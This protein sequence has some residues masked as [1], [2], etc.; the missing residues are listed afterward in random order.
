MKNHLIILIIF[1]VPGFLS[2][3]NLVHNW[4]FEDTIS[5]PDNATQINLSKYWFQPNVNG[6][7]SE[8]Y[9]S[10][11]DNNTVGVPKNGLGYQYACTG[12]SYA[13]I[14]LIYPSSQINYREYV[15][16]SF[17]SPLEQNKKYCVYFYASLANNTYYAIDKIGAYISKDSL[18][19]TSFS[20]INVQPQ[21][22]NPSGNIISDTLNWILISGD[23]ISNG[24]ENFIT[25]GN[26]YSDSSTN[27]EIIGNAMSDWAY[28]YIDDVSVTLCDD[29]S[30]E[31]ILSISNA[32]TPNGDGVNDIFKPHGKNI[33]SINGKIF[34][35][36]GMKLYEWSDVDSGWDGKYHDQ[37]VP[38]GAYFYI[39]IATFNDGE[40][41][42]KSGSVEVVR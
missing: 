26:F 14:G 42:E 3:Q 18:L 1:I 19:N 11:N 35:R 8:Y 30:S 38:P 6:S 22:E 31:N 28:Y 17:I 37:Y 33:K 7:S 4:S 15:E 32:F 12:V 34:N 29:T 13:G 23:Y 24:G 10:C 20:V 39:I 16:V 9:N 36:W 5:C 27:I 21:I 2:S 25:I 40:T 41:Q